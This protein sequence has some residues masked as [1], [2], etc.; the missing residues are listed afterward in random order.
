M[1]SRLILG[2]WLITTPTEPPKAGWG[3][4]IEG[5]SIA[6]VGPNAALRH[7]YPDD[8]VHEADGCVVAPGFVN[9]HT[10][11]YG[12]LAHGIPLHKA[13]TDFWSFLDDFW[14]PLVEDALDHKMI[15]AA[16][17]WVCAEMLRGGTTCF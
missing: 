11:L 5:D 7:D 14:W 6:A 10:H 16:T 4:R 17:D 8:E 2:D 15:C 9:S 1:T 12:T 3:V 13:P